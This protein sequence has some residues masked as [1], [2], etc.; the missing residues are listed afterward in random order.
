MRFFFSCFL[1][2]LAISF[3]GCDTTQHSGSDLATYN[4]PADPYPSPDSVWYRT[5]TGMDGLY[6][7]FVTMDRHYKRSAPPAPEDLH[8]NWRAQGWKG[9]RVHTKGIVWSAQR[10]REVRLNV[11]KLVSDEG[12]EIAGKHVHAEFLRFVLTDH[13]SHLA[14]GCGIP[15]GLD[16]S[17]VADIVDN[18]QYMDI[19]ARSSRPIWV[20]VDIPRDAVPGVYRG[21]LQV[22]TPTVNPVELPFQIE[23][24]PHT[25][26]EP[27]DW[28]F[29]LDLWQNP[30]S[31]ARHYGVRPWTDDHFRVMRPY[32]SRL[33]NA[34]QKV[35]TTS[36][37][38]DPW[39]SQTH[40]IYSSMIRW[41]K[42][43]DGSW[44][45]DYTHFDRW[46]EFMMS[47]GINKYINCYS[48]IPW[49]LKFQYYDEA[50]DSLQ[51]LHATP[52]S[53]EYKAHWLPMLQDF[54]QHLKDKGW[55]DIT[56]IAMDERPLEAMQQAI[57]IVKEA[58]PA[59]K[60]SLAGAYHPEIESE[61][62]DYSI[63]SGEPLDS[64]FIAARRQRGQVTTFYTCCTEP[65]PNTFTS[66]PSAEST[67]MG[68]HAL[69]QGLDGYLRW[70]YNNW[71]GNQLQDARFGKFAAGDAFLV[72]PGARSSVRFERLREG[73]QDYEKFKTLREYLLWQDKVEDIER[74][75]ALLPQFSLDSLATRSATD[76]VIHAKGILN[77]F[78]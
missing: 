71:N 58:D 74:L 11:G 44:A 63:A 73:I 4:E 45:Y 23:V 3:T 5:A 38:H 42:H 78:R 46:V 59:Y 66:S 49:D 75:E 26:P 68:W 77:S 57:A 18:V 54:A 15:N 34:G 7:S 65:R 72:Y 62:T 37:I 52:D 40:D 31:I 12:H 76:A 13:I 64:T 19:L 67:W 20:S 51:T 17:I 32:M 39:S 10:L 2:F 35:I 28:S 47:Q 50:S 22:R 16:T 21:V 29:H 9:E 56:M 69:Q 27:K 43:Q 30:F 55:W 36:I 41:T 24:L 14:S 1:L 33:A 61:L 25:L 60:I 70:G 53:D 48:M 6:A 8:A